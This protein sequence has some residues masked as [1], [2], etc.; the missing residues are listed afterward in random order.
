[1][2]GILQSPDGKPAPGVR[3][4]AFSSAPLSR[5]PD[6]QPRRVGLLIAQAAHQAPSAEVRQSFQD[7]TTTD[8]QGRF[9]LLVPTAGE[10]L[11]SSWPAKD[12]APSSEFIADKR[13]DVGAITL[14]PGR[15]LTG[16]IVA[17]DDKPVAGI[18][19]RAW[20]RVAAPD[21]SAPAV[22]QQHAAIWRCTRTDDQGSFAFAPLLPGEYVLEPTEVGGDLSTKHRGDPPPE[23]HP[24]PAYFAPQKVILSDNQPPTPL[25]I[26]PAPMVQIAGHVD[27]PLELLDAMLRQ[28]ETRTNLQTPQTLMDALRREREGRLP[29]PAEATGTATTRVPD[30]DELRQ[31]GPTI[32]GLINGIPYQT[33]AEIDVQGNFHVRTPR[34]LTDGILS[35][36]SLAF[37]FQ[38][39]GPFV[40]DSSRPPQPKWRTDKEKPLVTGEE[41]PIGK[42]EADIQGIEIVYPDPPQPAAPAAAP[43]PRA[44]GAGS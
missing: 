11:L 32:H 19:M 40:V 1:V 28:S 9:E 17:A 39:S 43:S 3:I 4:Y 37:G 20:L 13:G 44:R 24:L 34:G 30:A 38:P 23:K 10:T 18:Y 6:E 16:R 35:L 25:E 2:T 22:I 8:D 41:I 36:H 33:K 31:F 7:D 26:R 27:V 42:V 29:S 12:F 14:K 5:P 21:H 15:T